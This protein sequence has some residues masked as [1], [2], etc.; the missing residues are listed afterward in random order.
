MIVNDDNAIVAPLIALHKT[1]LPHFLL[2]KT[3]K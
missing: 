2:D 3:R 1:R